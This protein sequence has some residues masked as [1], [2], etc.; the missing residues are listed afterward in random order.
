MSEV[1]HHTENAGLADAKVV[2]V[3]GGVAGCSLAYHLTRLGWTDVALLEADQLTSGST[4]HAA[5]LCTQ[6]VPSLNLMKLLRSS[7]DLYRSLEDETGQRVDLHECGSVRLAAT[8]DRMD[9]FLH[10]RGIAELAGVPVEIVDPERVRE[11]FPLVDTA[12]IVG[13]AYLPT[14]GHVDPTSVTH[15]LASG[16]LS[17][18]ARV[19]RST[20][21]TAVER[22]RGTWVLQTP[23]GSLRGDIVVVAAGQWARGVGRMAGAE[24][25]IVP[26]QHHYVVTEPLP[27]VEAL[28]REL[29]VLRDADASFYVRQEGDGLLVGPFEPDPRPWALDGVPEGFHGR[30]LPADLDRIESVLA[31]AGERIPAFAEAGIKTVVN[32]PDG[33]T[34]DGRCLMGPV[35]GLPGFHVLAGFSIFGIVYGGGAGRYA[36]EWIV[37]GQPSD[38]MWELDVRRFGE[39]ARPTRYVADRAR[40]VYEREYAIHYPEEELTAGRPAKTDPLY[41][42]LR[43][44]GGV[45]G[46]RSGW[47][48]PLWFARDGLEA[49]DRYSFRRGNWHDAVGEECRAVRSAVGVLDQTS[50]AKFEVSG[51]GA[52]AVL[53]RLCANALPAETGRIVLTQMCT[54]L[55]GTECDVTVSRLADDRF[56]VVSAAA[57]ET[58][59]FAWLARHL[60]DGDAVRLENVTPRY[61]VLTLAG[62]RSRDLL[63]ALAREDVSREAFPFFRCRELELSVGPVL[64]LRVSYVGELGYELHH[65]LECQRALYEH[66]REAGEPLGLVDFGYRALESLRLEKAYRLW[67]SDMSQDWTPLEAGMERFVR[68]DK[69]PFVGRDALLR[70]R[71]AGLERTLACLAVDVDGADPYALEP[72][73]AG[74]R[75]VGY[76]TSGGFGHT[77][78][79][80]IALAYLP[81]DVAAPGAELTVEIL[82]DR[83]PAVVS[84]EPLYDPD[85]ERL[86]S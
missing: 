80:G 75:I 34:P 74:E 49:R 35:P 41:D 42:V 51:P 12:G 78:G 63:R 24:L 50:F 2:I 79:S 52:E 84:A 20:P 19:H 4:W 15:A 59:D 21:V 61:G 1:E 81:V 64:A 14:D 31:A 8:R 57:T 73:R 66:V 37:D 85:N 44:A 25:P 9:E 7:I 62:P 47:E 22:D 33:Y 68:L 40:E 65:P 76:V 86:L 27:E 13:A 82:G 60:P 54:P 83:R 46:V 53:D 77:V 56:Y 6:F 71:E 58:H 70:Q 10:R 5:G 23:S 67:G 26:L 30:L 55:G 32:G 3:G 28:E 39:Y 45:F 36:A 16:A 17:R 69:G 18:G 72:V 43:A 11:L 29:P 48:R 38:N